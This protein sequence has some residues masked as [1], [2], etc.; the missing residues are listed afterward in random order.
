MTKKQQSK[1]TEVVRDEQG[2]VRSG[3]PN[4]G[5]L[6]RAQR[7]VRAAV[8]T[9]LDEAFT[10]PDGT[11][12]LVDAIKLG[13]SIGD[14]SIIRLACEYRWGKPTQP[15]EIDPSRMGDEELKKSVIEIAEQWKQEDL[16]H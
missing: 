14:G 1:P 5:G 4:P 6:T 9:L 3:T 8:R 7:E 16:T 15:V 11:D 2:R 10:G 12:V 13:V